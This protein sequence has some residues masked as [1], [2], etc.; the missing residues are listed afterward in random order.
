[1]A[2][3]VVKAPM[4]ARVIRFH[5]QAGATVE[6][7]QKVCDIEA[8]KMEIAVFSPIAGTIKEIHAAAGEQVDADVPLFT[9][10]S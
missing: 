10:E 3:Q 1:M 9:V 8:L 5:A 7:N 2:E 4:R 6:E